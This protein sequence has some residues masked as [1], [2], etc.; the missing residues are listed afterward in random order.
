MKE[1]PYAAGVG[2]V[3]WVREWNRRTSRKN[4]DYH[5]GTST[6]RWLLRGLLPGVVVATAVAVLLGA[7]FYGDWTRL[8]FLPVVMAVLA[9]VFRALALADSRADP[10]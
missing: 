4:A 1:P 3:S 6:K 2:A 5:T 8:V 7:V 9:W 10:R